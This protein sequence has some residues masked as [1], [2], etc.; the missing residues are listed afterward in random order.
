MKLMTEKTKR[1]DKIF[2]ISVVLLVLSGVFIFSSASLGL[3]AKEGPTLQ[4]VVFNQL[5]LGLFLGTVA[6]FVAAK[7]RYTFWRKWSF[8]IFLAAIALNL[9]V[10]VPGLG[11]S[12]GGATRWIDIFDFS[13]QPS[14]FL[15]LGFILYLAAWFAGLKE[16][17]ETFKFGL[18]P[19][20]IFLSILASLLLAQ[21]DTDTLV[22]L[23]AV[24]FIMF[25]LSGG[26]P[27]DV[28]ILCLIGLLGFGVLILERPYVR[29]RIE[30]FLNPSIDPQG[31]SYQIQQSLIAV[32]SG[33]IFGRGFGQSIQKFKYLPEPIGDSIFAVAAEE[34]GF[35]GSS[36]LIFLFL[37]FSFRGLRIASRSP[38]LFGGLLVSGI[39]VLIVFQ[40][41]MNI[42]A[43]LGVIPLSGM[44]LLFISHGG[45]ALFFTLFEVG[46]IVNISRY[47][48]LPKS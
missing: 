37:L 19:L 31:S 42:A 41:F 13:F 33:K 28:I 1:P 6:F 27:R 16:K 14:E 29:E 20:L 11:F 43:M 9:I 3:L 35:V 45:T 10:F 24:A 48:S 47:R 44:P 23:S 4:S 15:K 39:V 34:F 2:F 18:L 17:I 21:R 26:R 25:L 7:V 30:T 12:H 5:F 22:V 46:L 40:S 36:L 8:Y 38:D 32:G